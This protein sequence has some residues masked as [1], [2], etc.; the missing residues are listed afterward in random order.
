MIVFYTDGA[1]NSETRG[2]VIVRFFNVETK[3]ENWNS[4][5][6]I[7]VIDVELF[8][9]E[10]AIEFCSK[11]AYSI[12]IASDIWIFTDY[13]NA[14]TRLERFDFRT[15]LMEKL[16][17][18]CKELYKVGHKIHIHWIPGHAK[19]SRNLQADE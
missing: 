10:K 4:G 5:R 9:I 17:R 12:R 15:H 2:A 8:V 1:N 11:K 3:A 16:H 7:D 18:N 19:I 13:A 6:Y 14:I